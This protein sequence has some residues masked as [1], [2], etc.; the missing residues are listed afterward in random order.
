MH[1]IIWSRVFLSK[2]NNFQTDLFG[3]RWEPNRFNHSLSEWTK[4]YWQCK[5]N[6]THPS[7]PKLKPHHQIQFSVLPR[8]HS[9]GPGRLNPKQEILLMLHSQGEDHRQWSGRPGFNPRSSHTKLK[10]KIV[11]DTSLLNNQH[12]KVRI[13]G[14]VEQSSERRSPPP[15]HLG[16]V[17]IEK[18]ALEYSR[19]LYID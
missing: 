18:K 1:T 8:T 14:K 9:F 4:E 12:Y 6:S 11:L 19:Q 16:V 7:F 2:S 15:L 17:A 5:G 3:W 10:K 13:K